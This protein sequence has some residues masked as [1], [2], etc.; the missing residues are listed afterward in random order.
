MNGFANHP[1][2][3]AVSA[4]TS[5][6]KR[7]SYSN[8]GNEIWVSAPSNG[9]GGMGILTAD[10]IG[11]YGYV[12]GDYE[13]EFGGTSSACPLT[14]GI[15]ALVLSVKPS[16]TNVQ[17]KDILRRS[18]RKIGSNYTNGHSPYFGYGCVNALEAVKLAGNESPI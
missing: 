14:A 11:Q 2:V 9:A 8:Y 6:D 10:V 12:S 16:L 7:S 3:I 4:S 1:D 18:A 15:C 17:V 13:Y 5:R